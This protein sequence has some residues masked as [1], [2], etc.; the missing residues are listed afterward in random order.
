MRQKYKESH[1]TEVE[2]YMIIK[3]Y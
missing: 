3:L 1:I 2:S